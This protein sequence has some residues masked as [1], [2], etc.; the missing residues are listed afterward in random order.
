[1]LLKRKGG[2]HLALS[3]SQI[4]EIIYFGKI[5]SLYGKCKIDPVAQHKWLDCV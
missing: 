1:M 3:I 2:G 4:I 5:N